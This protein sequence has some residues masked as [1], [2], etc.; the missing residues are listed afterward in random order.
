MLKTQFTLRQYQ[1]SFIRELGTAVKQHKRVI[2]CAATGAGKSKTFLQIAANAAKKRYT[3]LIITE[4]RPIYD[5][6]IAEV[7]ATEINSGNKVNH[8][9]PGGIYLAMAQTL[10][11]RPY[12]IEQ[13]KVI[14]EAPNI[15]L[16]NGLLI[17]NDEC[18]INQAT[19]ILKQL[20]NAMLIGCSGSPVGRHLE[21]LYRHLVVGPQPHDLVLNGYLT[22]YWHFERKRADISQ[23]ELD[24]SGEYTEESQENVFS[25]DAVYDGLIED[26][27]N[28]A[29]TWKKAL[30]F[31]SSIKH[32]EATAERLRQAGLRC[33]TVHS[34]VEDYPLANNVQPKRGQTLEDAYLEQ[35][36]K[37]L[38]PI[39]VSVSILTKGFDYP[40]TDFI[41]QLFKTT[42]LAKYL[43]TI[44][45][46]SR[47]LK[48]EELLPIE[49]R[50]KQRFY[51]F[52]YGQNCTKHLPWDFER[53]WPTLWRSKPKRAGV[54]PIKT[55]PQCDYINAASA[56]VCTFCGYTWPV[57]NTEEQ[58]ENPETILV[59][60]TAKYNK[61]V[62]RKLSELT[63]EE[64][65]TYAKTKGYKQLAMRVAKWHCFSKGLE[66]DMPGR[67][68]LIDYGAYMGYKPQ[69]VHIQVEAM[70]AILRSN[71]QE[72][73]AFTD[74]VLR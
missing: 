51:V 30:I 2:G 60:V 55:C 19:G 71:P 44:G 31:T 25:T 38:T 4:A 26:L 68:W 47:V 39:C 22:P 52:D 48:G 56:K 9:L 37:G 53:D 29:F 40:P 49:Q 43:Q 34:E 15:F 6:L 35:F 64:L 69:W 59:E 50:K 28:P 12:L 14:S 8:I 46:A 11:R 65:S 70:R 33:V 16:T 13:F 27:T 32:C 17:I 21:Q 24:H 1:Q 18:H 74:K 58:P 62:G 66:R 63:P 3:V 45:R 7:H 10:K 72:T 36:T 5:Q 61:L 41:G 67:Q 73:F 20:P 42:S 57:L 23:L 54:S